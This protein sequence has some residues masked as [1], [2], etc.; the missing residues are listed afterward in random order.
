[1]LMYGALGNSEALTNQ[2]RNLSNN[3]NVK[4][5]PV[6]S[7][8]I[9]S[10]LEAG[11]TVYGKD[12][13]FKNIN[14]NDYIIFGRFDYYDTMFATEGLVFN[15]PRWKRETYTL[16]LVVKIINDVHVKAQY[17][18]RKVGAPAPTSINGGTLEKSFICG[19]AFEF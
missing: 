11:A 9:G 2:N 13:I 8:A 1:M 7:A 19:F 3:L 6:G 15:N 5:T 16:G 12:G 10:F 4:R 18:V 14:S 17:S